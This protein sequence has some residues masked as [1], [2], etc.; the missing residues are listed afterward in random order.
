M[1]NA[2]SADFL[3]ILIVK[4]SDLTN[5]QQDEILSVCSRA[6]EEDFAPYLQLLTSATH[7]LAYVGNEL[8]SH[9]A[10]V[11]RE[12][13]QEGIQLCEQHILR[14]LLRSRSTNARAMGAPS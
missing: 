4:A 8:A 7:V 9:A 5:G 6:Y 10:W 1:T 14:P 13:H 11:E 2:F 12:L 3:L